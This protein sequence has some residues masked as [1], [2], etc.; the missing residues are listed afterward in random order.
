MLSLQTTPPP[1]S[2]GVDE[3][4]GLSNNAPALGSG[5]LGGGYSDLDAMNDVEADS[6]PSALDVFLAKWEVTLEE[7]RKVGE[8]DE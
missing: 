3:P 4:A 1:P 2:V 8:P 5:G 6:G 7:K